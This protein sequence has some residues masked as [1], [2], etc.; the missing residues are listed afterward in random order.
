M[1]CNAWLGLG[2]CLALSACGSK[3]PRLDP[4]FAR[5]L[6]EKRA[7][8]QQFAVGETNPIPSDTW[9]F[10]DLIERSDWKGATKVYGNLR[11]QLPQLSLS[12]PVAYDGIGGAILKWYRGQFGSQPIHSGLNGPLWGAVHDTMGIAQCF[13]E[14]DRE[15][16]HQFGRDIIDSIPT[17]SIYFGGTDAGRFIITALSRSHRDGRP[18]Y[19]LTQNAFAKLR[20]SIAGLYVWRLHHAGSEEEK[21]AMRK[22]ANYA[23][24]QAVALCPYSSEIVSRAVNYFVSE[25]LS[26]DAALISRTRQRLIDLDAQ[27]P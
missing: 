3:K 11:E 18:F 13:H 20:S 17:N 6:A 4:D 14:W 27:A 23:F 15:L 25:G 26:D 12:T 2:L 19:T 10:F 24:R 7:L 21:A 22:E 9:K 5:A 1:K 8:A 16:L